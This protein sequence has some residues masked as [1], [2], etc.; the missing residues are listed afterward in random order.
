MNLRVARGRPFHDTS[1]HASDFPR[2]C[3]PKEG[4]PAVAGK[5]TARSAIPFAVPLPRVFEFPTRHL[6]RPGPAKPHPAAASKGGAA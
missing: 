1:T 4:L 2:A 6:A 3:P 5:K